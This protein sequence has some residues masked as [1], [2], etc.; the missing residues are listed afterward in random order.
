MIEDMLGVMAICSSSTLFSAPTC[1]SSSPRFQVLSSL[2]VV[3][4]RRVICQL[5]KHRQNREIEWQ[6]TA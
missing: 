3:V 2:F 1:T 6:P 5:C 4:R